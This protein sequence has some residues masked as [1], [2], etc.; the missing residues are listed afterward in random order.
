[1][2]VTAAAAQPSTSADLS[3]APSIYLQGS[4]ADGGTHA[5]TVG[6]TLPWNGWSYDLWGGQVRGFWDIYATRLSFD[7]IHGHDR[8][9]MLGLTP[10]LRWRAYNGSSP[11]FVQAGIGLSY[12]T[13]RYI[14]VH[15][16]FSTSFNFASHLGVGYSFGEQ[17]RH[18]LQLRVE[19]ISNAGIKH[20]NPGEN[21]AQLRYAYHF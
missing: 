21:F 13:D 16:E 6:M 9:W 8:S 10:T 7:G 4:G 2:L 3:Q 15:K 14:T 19:H 20:P 5:A 17:R 11:W 18:E 12:M 1:M